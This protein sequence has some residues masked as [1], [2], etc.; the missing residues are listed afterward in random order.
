[1]NAYAKYLV[2]KLKDIDKDISK[3]VIVPCYVDKTGKTNWCKD[4]IP[5][6]SKK[7][8]LF[9]YES[10]ISNARFLSSS[11]SRTW[12]SAF[13]FQY[14]WQDDF[15]KSLSIDDAADAILCESIFMQCMTLSEQQNIYIDRKLL[16][17]KGSACEHMMM[18]ELTA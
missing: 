2:K 3:I 1:M 7:C 5:A 8:I 10:H 17:A 6:N 15:R 16:F 14:S 9:G 11:G 18:A 13:K 4:D 12:G